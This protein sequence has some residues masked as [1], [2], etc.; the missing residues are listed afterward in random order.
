MSLPLPP[1]RLDRRVFLA[2]LAMS[3]AGTAA[4]GTVLF[5]LSESVWWFVLSSALSLLGAG[6]YLGWRAREP[7]PPLYGALLAILYFGLAVAILFGGELAE[8]LPDPLPGLDVGDSTFFFI[9]PLLM[10]T[11]GFV[12]SILGRRAALRRKGPIESG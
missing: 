8:K 9:S 7:E 6:F 3:V 5:L 12:G 1:T 4:V 11:A 10:L 2:A